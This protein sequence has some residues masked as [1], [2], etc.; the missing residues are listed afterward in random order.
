LLLVVDAIEEA[1][2]KTFDKHCLG[3]AGSGITAGPRPQIQL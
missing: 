2:G 1:T 3:A